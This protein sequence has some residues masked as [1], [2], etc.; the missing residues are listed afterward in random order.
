MTEAVYR[1]FGALPP[2]MKE[3]S[4]LHSESPNTLPPLTYD[5][6]GGFEDFEEQYQFLRHHFLPRIE[7]AKLKLSF[8]KLKLIER[9]IK[10]LGVTHT[11]GGFVQVLEDRIGKIV[12]WEA[13]RDQTGR[14]FLGVVGFTRKILAWNGHGKNGTNVLSQAI[15]RPRERS[16]IES[17]FREWTNLL[18]VPRHRYWEVLPNRMGS[19]EPRTYRNA[20]AKHH[21]AD[22]GR[23]DRDDQG[24][25]RSGCW[26]SNK[27]DD[28]SYFQEENSYI[29]PNHFSPWC[30]VIS[31]FEDSTWH[32]LYISLSI[33][34]TV[35]Q[36]IFS[37]S[38]QLLS[39]LLLWK[40]PWKMMSCVRLRWRQVWRC[41]SESW[42]WTKAP[43][44]SRI[45]RWSR[46]LSRPVFRNNCLCMLCGEALPEFDIVWVLI[47][48]WYRSN[49]NQIIYRIIE[50]SSSW[51][52]TCPACYSN[53]AHDMIMIMR[54]FAT[55][56]SCQPLRRFSPIG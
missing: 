47:L 32:H 23:G 41:C 17:S 35:V 12:A 50:L 5:F 1:A 7:W 48:Q 19:H 25:G 34:M 13:P 53:R 29:L 45:S 30:P 11:I 46:T 52:R 43:R 54:T 56:R 18:A 14:S 49:I 31:H 21:E 6:F 3:P 38:Q 33:R 42:T 20:S 40:N 55:L 15:P 27:R 26:L 2:P 16:G 51:A 8:K 24:P 37:N 4:L 39:V 44:S 9:S 22:N 36:S 28:D 10:A